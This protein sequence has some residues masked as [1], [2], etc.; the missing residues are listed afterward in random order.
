M[1]ALDRLTALPIGSRR[2]VALL[3][4]AAAL[5]AAWWLIVMPLHWL[6]TSQEAWRT[7]VRTELARSRGEA[8]LLPALRQRLTALPDDP[9]WNRFYGAAAGEEVDSLVR[10]DV[11]QICSDSQVRVG[12]L[13]RLPSH[14]EGSLVAY[15]VRLTVSATPDRLRSFVDHLRASPRY[16][17][18]ERLHISAPDTQQPGQNPLLTV[19]ADIFGFMRSAEPSA[20]GAPP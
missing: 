3:M 17:R 16:L 1:T 8:D 14:V 19:S 2:S 7:D 13:V 10:Q 18:V 6:I 20:R 11:T 15:G 5:L 4:L 12:S 9:I